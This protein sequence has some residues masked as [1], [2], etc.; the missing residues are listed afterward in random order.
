[1]GVAG[2]SVD[3]PAAVVVDLRVRGSGLGTGGFGPT[4]AAAVDRHTAI[5]VVAE[6]IQPGGLALYGDGH[7]GGGS[8]ALAVGDRV[9]EPVLADEAGLRLIP[10]RAVRP[11]GQLTVL[12]PT[13]DAAGELVAVGVRVVPEDAGAAESR[14][15]CRGPCCTG[16]DVPPDGR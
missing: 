14:G 13:L 7:R 2:A 11:E 10:E 12:G 6:T 16:R 4:G 8:A 9:G 15:P 5:V 3:T 1:M